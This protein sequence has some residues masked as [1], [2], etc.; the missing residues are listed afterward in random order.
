[1]PE[2]SVHGPEAFD[3][4]MA[5]ADPSLYIATLA[6]GEERAGC[7]VGFAAQ[8]SIDP[9]RFLVCLSKNNHTYRISGAAQHMAVHLVGADNMAL[10]ALFG[11]ETGDEMDKFS[12]T[13]WRVGPHGVPIIL[14][15][16]AWFCGRIVAR[17]DLGDHVGFVIEP[18]D[19]F[20]PGEPGAVVRLSHATRLEP[21]H[22]A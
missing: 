20:A 15:T 18:E 8:V 3:A 6:V 13:P 22:P 16:L 17:H 4:V 2:N 21:G 7:L 11:A 1:M 19:G 5:M 12:W 14:D 9:A 10:A